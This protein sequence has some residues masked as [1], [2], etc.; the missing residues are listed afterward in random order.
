MKKILI[1]G[2]II[3][4]SLFLFAC[5]KT[6]L[7]PS[8]QLNCTQAGYVSIEDANALVNLTNKLVD[9][10]NYCFAGQ[11]LTSLGHIKYWS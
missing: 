6:K 11:N 1:I 4:F 10:T 3:C 7:P 2:L 9:I 8:E 5:T